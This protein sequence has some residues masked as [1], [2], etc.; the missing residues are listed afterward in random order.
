MV[1][2]ARAGWYNKAVPKNNAIPAA[3]RFAQPESG[4]LSPVRMP[5]AQNTETAGLW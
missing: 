1:A 2:A 5:A 3:R 4:R